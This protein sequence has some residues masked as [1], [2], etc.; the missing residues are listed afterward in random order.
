MIQVSQA[1]RSV[2]VRVP[3]QVIA[4]PSRAN[5]QRDDV[6]DVRVDDVVAGV[7][8]MLAMRDPYTARHQVRTSELSVAIAT[9]L[10]GDTEFITNVAYAAALHDVGKNGVPAEIL[11]SARL[12]T[13][14][15]FAVMQ[16]HAQAGHDV[17]ASIPS[18]TL[19]A[20][21]VLQHHERLD[22]TG[23]PNHLVGGDIGLGARILGVAD[24]VEAMTSVRP[25][26]P[27]PGIAA[28]LVELESGRGT[29]YDAAV[30]DACLHLCAQGFTFDTP[31]I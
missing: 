20:T 9:R 23:Y 27:A 10:D 17:L 11:T 15:E 22:G 2:D 13:D 6:V 29:R 4:A 7:L 3:A 25:Y 19:V 12:L 8:A 16:A 5:A 21:F 1:G 28:A 30:V 26:R 24:T 31:P 14:A 18:F